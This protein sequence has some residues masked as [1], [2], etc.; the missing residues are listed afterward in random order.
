MKSCASAL[1]SLLAAAC[2]LAASPVSALERQSNE[3]AAFRAASRGDNPAVLEL[4]NTA[5]QALRDG[6]PEQAVALLERGLRIEPHNPV[7]WHYL[8]AARLD[9]GH[10][11]QA[12]ALAAKSHS[13]GAADRTL[14]AGNAGLMAAAQ[15]ASGK[16]VAVPSTEPPT[17]A[18]RR[19][20]AAAIE[21]ARDYARDR[22]DR[23][24]RSR[25]ARQDECRV[26]SNRGTRIVSCG[27]SSRRLPAARSIVSR[28]RPVA[29]IDRRSYRRY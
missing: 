12:E 7:V 23:A 17:L 21:P 28:S 9:L 27:E 22:Y 3:L 8:A 10:Y 29:R 14:R 18:S 11:A 1:A 15:Q 13:L 16:P 25:A 6:R 4:L 26:F 19:G 5:E 24:L 2:A 20:L